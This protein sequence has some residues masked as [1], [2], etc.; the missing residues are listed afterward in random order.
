VPSSTISRSPESPRR[1][2]SATRKVAVG[3]GG[4]SVVSLGAAA[5]LGVV[6][7]WEQSDASRLCPDAG[8]P[9]THS[10]EANALVRAG[11]RWALDANVAWSI[12]GAAALASGVM[13]LIGAPSETRSPQISVVPAVASGDFNVLVVRRSSW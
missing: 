3:L 6:A 1:S 5:A 8:G 2:T 13:W 9:C 10:A 7:K 12:A 11:N 4:V